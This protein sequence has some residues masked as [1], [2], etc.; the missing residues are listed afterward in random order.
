MAESSTTDKAAIRELLAAMAPTPCIFLGCNN[1]ATHEVR[2]EPWRDVI[3]GPDESR[4]KDV[5]YIKSQD[6][7]SS[8]CWDQR[9]IWRIYVVVRDGHHRVAAA[10]PLCGE[11]GYGS[12]GV[13]GDWFNE[14]NVKSLT[15]EAA[16]KYLYLKGYPTDFH[17]A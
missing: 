16:S 1:V 5:D 9:A 12:R 17:G 11:C 3:A 14:E 15:R 10:F 8:L 4:L 6:R 13:S 2:F 7:F